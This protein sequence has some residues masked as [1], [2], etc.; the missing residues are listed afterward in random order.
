VHGDPF[1]PLQQKSFTQRILNIYG[2]YVLR[3]AQ[4]IRV[5]SKRAKQSLVKLGVKEDVITVLPIMQDLTTFQK[6]ARN[7]TYTNQLPRTFVFV[8]RLAPEKNIRYIIQA[9][10]RAYDS[11]ED[12]R[13]KIVGQG[14]CLPELQELTDQLEVSNVVTFIPWTDDVSEHMASA[15][16]FVFASLHEGYALVL[17]E[18]MAS[19]LPIITTDV[20]CVGE[21]CIDAEHC[22]V[23]SHDDGEQY[24]QAILR[25][26]ED[27]DLRKRYGTQGS[28]TILELDQSTTAYLQQWKDS[29]Q[30]RT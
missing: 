20:G 2:A 14:P 4:A 5:V 12:I 8:G 26:A 25:L 28:G 24:T 13:L 15:D 6:V 11:Q 16:V 29:F 18:A 17:L 7:R 23:V 19:G 30:G 1:S 22:L 3:H 21:V 27:A 10:A 9:F